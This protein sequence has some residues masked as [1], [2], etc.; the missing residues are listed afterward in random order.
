MTVYHN[1]W[2]M[3]SPAAL[4]SPIRRA[5]ISSSRKGPESEQQTRRRLSR[6]LRKEVMRMPLYF[7]FH[8]G[9]YT[10]TIVIKQKHHAKK[11]AATPRK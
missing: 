1:L 6:S 9:K 11:A 5:I 8:I 3:D 2:E 7:T 4:T 10:I